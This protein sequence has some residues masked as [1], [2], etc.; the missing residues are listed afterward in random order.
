VPEVAMLVRMNS[1][2][3][4]EL[5]VEVS[6]VYFAVLADL[7]AWDLRCNLLALEVY[8]FQGHECV[9]Y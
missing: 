5:V 8:V 6:E 9:V 2:T 7:P 1:V 3:H 4:L